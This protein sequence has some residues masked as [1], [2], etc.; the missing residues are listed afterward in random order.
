MWPTDNAI[1]AERPYAPVQRAQDVVR[2]GN[3]WEIPP[4]PGRRAL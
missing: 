3:Y 2:D 1:S 4:V